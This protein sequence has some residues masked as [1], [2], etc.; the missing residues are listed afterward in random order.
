MKVFPQIGIHDL[1]S[2]NLS[3]D[4]VKLLYA[5]SS[6]TR[7]ELIDLVSYEIQGLSDEEITNSLRTSL[8]T[9][10]LHAP[11]VIVTVPSHA[12]IAKNIE[13]PSLIRQEIM[14]IVDLQAGRHTPYSREEIIIDYIHIG[15]FRENYTKIL[16]IIV[17][18]SVVRRQIEILENAGLKIEKVYFSPEII[19]HVLS[20]ILKLGQG[21]AVQTIVHIDA[22]F[23]DFINISK[24][25]VIFVR[26]I[27]IG[28]HHLRSEPERYRMR[29]IEEIK[30]SMET[31]QS[32]DI[33]SM[34]EEMILTGAVR[35]G[36]E[37]QDLLSKM[38]FMPVTIFH[39][40]TH[41]PMGSDELKKS[42]A[43][44]Q[45]SFLDV[46]APVISPGHVSVNLIP[47]EIKLRKKF[48]EKSK[49]LVTS[50]VYILT[51]LALLCLVFI[52]Q[53]F[54]KASYLKQ[55][56][57]KYQPV[58]ESSKRL[59]KSFS[60]MRSI[61]MELKNRDAAI[62]VLAELH[63]LLPDDIQLSA[64]KFSFDGNLTLE[65]NSR[66]MGT[67]FSFIGDMEESDRFKSVESRRTT[68]R[69]IGEGEIV[70][71]DIICILED[72]GGKTGS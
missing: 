48:E 65:G 11:D 72:G 25:K 19:A 23:S 70:D 14:E 38:L 69:K 33:G 1:V 57:D 61:K 64:I 53:I 66:T 10:K 39:Y 36:D 24:G 42:L 18:V 22:N 50:G 4:N 43:V 52:G 59:E 5:R 32:E 30:K 26:S 12:T 27:P 9:L 47:E 40:L 6:P 68:K 28:R 17:T 37:I 31:Y 7:K 62:N 60:Q 49:E 20:G 56:T 71:F 58:I 41:A 44:G 55:L 15:T 8:N 45:D 16:L 21:E 3:G 34:P 13:I 2:V 35:E 51:I 46:I 54:V 63:K 67:V 29:F